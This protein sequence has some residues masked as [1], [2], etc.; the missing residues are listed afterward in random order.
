MPRRW[1]VVV[2]SGVLVL[3]VAAVAVV[4]LVHRSSITASASSTR[5]GLD[6]GD[7]VDRDRP[8]T[9]D[10]DRAVVWQSDG[11]TVGAWVRLAWSS[12][13]EVDHVEVA[14]TGA[15]GT[16]FDSAA[17]E[18][19]GGPSMLLTTDAEGMA[20]VDFPAR[21]VSSVRL[22][23][24]TV[25]DGTASVALTS[26]TVDDSGS[27]VLTSPPAAGVTTATSSAPDAP[28]LIDGDVARGATGDSWTAPPGGDAWVQLAWPQP[29]LVASVQ[30]FGPAEGDVDPTQRPPTPLHGVLRFDDGSTV[31]V[32]GIAAGGGPATTI[33]FT[34]RTASS[35][36]LELAT[37]EPGADVPVSLRELAVYDAGTT[38][39]PWPQ[40]ADGQPADSYEVTPPTASCSSAS[41]PTGRSSGGGLALVCPEPGSAV[42]GSTTLVVAG[43]AGTAVS[44]TASLD[45]TGDSPGVVQE[46]ASGTTD[47][48]GRASLTVDMTALAEGPTAVRVDVAQ[49]SD[50]PAAVPLYVQLVN[51]SG[52]ALDAG[53]HAPAGMTLQYAEE[54]TEPLSISRDGAGAEYAATKPSYEQG[55]SFGDAAFADPASGTGTLGTVDSQYLRIRAQGTAPTGAAH[56]SGILSSAR[57]GGSGFAAQYG[58][59]EARML[60]APGVGSWPAFWMLDTE[61]T[62]PRGVT[63]GEVDAVELY[64][65]DTTGSCHTT[66]NWGYGSDD[67]GVADC[68]DDNGFADWALVWH[69]YGVRFVPGGAD[70][71]IDGIQVSTYRGLRQAADPY[72]FLVDLALGGGWP[73]DLASTGE[74]TDLYVD[75][76]HAYT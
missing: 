61:N 59:F 21:R 14:T 73:V 69:T 41:P 53:G 22:V 23:I 74:V 8:S 39:P 34:P 2:L 37:T 43:P 32:S 72:Y 68:L 38:P 17:L 26:L 6:A 54:F 15:A 45:P 5:P 28:A 49:P 76:I 51:R 29:R 36:R 60:G 50:D 47:S 31:V 33:A 12:A 16:G 67:G 18:F 42:S 52:I 66:H 55:G 3:A 40:G 75:W 20:S 19:D 44:A 25:P 10:D 1:L 4:L 13:T 64:G 71:F 11:E 56:E 65:H 48:S 57:V 46:V 58:Y 27:P 30:V 62:T 35:V 63:A 70:F 9:A 7:L 24:A